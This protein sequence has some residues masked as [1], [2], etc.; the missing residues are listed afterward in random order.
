MD[1]YKEAIETL[2]KA[3]S[4]FIFNNSSP[5]HANIVLT[6][7]LKHTIKEF[8]VY[9]DN[10]SGDIAD[11]DNE[12]Y[13]TLRQCVENGKTIKIVVDKIQS[14]ENKIFS[15]LSELKSQF[16]DFVYV[17]IASEEFKTNVTRLYDKPINFAVND[18][19]SF[20]MEDVSLSG[21]RQAKAI[22]SFNNYEYSHKLERAFDLEFKNCEI[23]L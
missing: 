1:E 15:F 10:L 11:K 2:A 3:K 4:D 19:N 20:R 7:M 16:K 21:L 14:K 8:K 22:C 23:V 13:E 9:D 5:S 17:S 18:I 6:T 12:F